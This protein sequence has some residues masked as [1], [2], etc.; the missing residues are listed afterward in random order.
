MRSL[1][2]ALLVNPWNIRALS[3]TIVT[4]LTMGEEEK[5]AR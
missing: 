4:A 1:V 2:G 5:K 3:E